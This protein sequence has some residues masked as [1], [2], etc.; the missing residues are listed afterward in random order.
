MHFQCWINTGMVFSD[1]F[2][3]QRY[4]STIQKKNQCKSI[5]FDAKHI[6]CLFFVGTSCIYWIQKRITLINSWCMQLFMVENDTERPDMV[7]NLGRS[8]IPW[9]YWEKAA[10]KGPHFNAKILKN[11][12]MTWA[13]I[14]V[15]ILNSFAWYWRCT[16]VLS[17]VTFHSEYTAVKQHIHGK[18]RLWF[19]LFK[20]WYFTFM[21]QRRWSF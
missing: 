16:R 14:Q 5:G 12:L 10:L 4:V 15:R 19:S 13:I 6:F 1:A 18:L 8:K 9:L 17:L 2:S 20:F 11:L 3:V 21:H 7:W